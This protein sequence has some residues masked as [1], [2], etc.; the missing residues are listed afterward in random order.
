MVIFLDTPFLARYI[1]G[2]WWDEPTEGLFSAMNDDEHNETIPKFLWRKSEPNGDR[3]E[4]CVGFNMFSYDFVDVSCGFEICGICDIANAPTFVLRGLCTNS[5]FDHHYGWTGDLDQSYKYNFR[6]FEKSLITWNEDK[7]YW[8]LQMISD[9]TIF[10][11]SNETKGP[12]P[13]GVNKWYIFN[14]VTCLNKEIDAKNHVY[15]TLLSF[16]ACTNEEFN[17]ED[18][19]W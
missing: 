9:P 18:G 7:K 5:I 19:S 8:K 15:S 13:F 17:C 2:G 12:Y 10:A 6:G 4:N 3:F 14:D 11:I 1:W 16:S